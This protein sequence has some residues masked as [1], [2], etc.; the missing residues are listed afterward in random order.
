MSAPA[1]ALRDS[2]PLRFPAF[3]AFLVAVFLVVASQEGAQAQ[4]DVQMKL[5]RRLYMAYEPIIA[6]VSITNRTGRDVVFDEFEGKQWFGFQISTADNRPVPPRDPDYQLTPLSVPAGQSVKR[7]VNLVALYP[8]TDFGLYRIRAT[9]FYSE[10]NRYFSSAPSSVEISEGK[11]MWQQTVGIPT[12]EPNAGGLRIYKLLS[13]RQPKDNM[14]YVRVEDQEE[15]AIYGVYAIGHLIMGQEPQI[16]LDGRNRLHV[17]QLVAPKTFVH[18]RIG[19]NGEWFGQ[20]TYTTLRTRPQL[21]RAESGEIAVVGG[22]MDVPVAQ[23]VHGAPGAA[24]QAP[25][26]LSDRPPGMPGSR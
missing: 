26:K 18:T 7:S 10:M 24:G 22:Q 2:V 5:S 8:I 3:A 14:L 21:R 12:G 20:T 16:Q 4:I 9:V 19:I 25:P 11:L 15:G 6:T 1:R 13:F 17:L 23:P